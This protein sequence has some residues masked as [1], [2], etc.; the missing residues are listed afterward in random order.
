MLPPV[1]GAGMAEDPEV[2]EMLRRKGVEYID[3]HELAGLFC[4]EL[5]LAP[6][7]DDGVMFMKRLP[8]VKA[9]RI[10]DAVHPLP[11]GELGGG[12]VSSRG[13]DF[14]MLEGITTLDLGQGRL[15]A[16]RSFS[17]EKDLWMADHKPFKFIPHPLVSAAM[18]LE[19]S[20]EAARIL[21]P[22]L[23]VR[24][25]RRMRFVDMILC[26][27]GI[28][29]ACRISCRRVDALPGEAACEVSLSA[30]EMSPAGRLTDRYALCDLGQ[31]I[32]DGGHGD[33]GEGFS[34][35]PIRPDEVRTHPM[36]HHEVLQWYADGSG[37]GERY[38][39]IDFLEGAAPGAVRGQT[40]YRRRSDF[41]HL[42]NA[43]YQ[44]SP[45]LFEA[46]LQLVALSRVAL[47]PTQRQT[48]IP[49]EV[50]EMRF[51]R[52][53]REGERIALEARMRTEDES[54]FVWDARGSDDQ[55]RPIMQVHGMRMRKAAE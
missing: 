2:R 5:F 16:V 40:T 45:Y 39:V 31:V 1:E 15:E 35:F 33:L 43:Q 8:A 50:G 37:F 53:C 21:Y 11:G 47:D 3:V 12:T 25:I 9:A 55:G 23:Q 28:L 4:R 34:D 48:M 27:P 26:P 10:N 38:R 52:T 42:Q 30:Q 13:E 24:G 46:L 51:L 14:P 6:A 36:D 20:M 54:G 44:Y 29:R 41:A 18:V 7:D 19:T 17:L 22:Y 32:L 49:V